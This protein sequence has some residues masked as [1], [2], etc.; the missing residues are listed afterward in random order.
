MSCM[1]DIKIMNLKT[2]KNYFHDEL[3]KNYSVSEIDS[4]FFIVISF[5]LEIS[6]LDYAQNSLQKINKTNTQTIIKKIE[7]LKKNMP[8]QYVLG[9]VF[10]KNI[11]FYLNKKVLIP[12]PETEELCDWIISCAKE[13]SNILD[14]GT[15][16][17]FIA[18][19]LKKHINNCKV[20][21]WDY[22]LEALKVAEKNA[23]LNNI[24]VT[25]RKVDILKNYNLNSKFDI[26]VS[27]P[28]YVDIS[29]KDEINA[30]VK[31]FEPHS[32]VFV[33]HYDNMIFYKK[34]IEQSKRLLKKNGI[35]YF[36][37]HSSRIN[38]LENMLKINNFK[39]IIIKEDMFGKK[40][41]I[42]AY[43]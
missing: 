29:E 25:L 15:G 13:K 19:I 17:G 34:I 27:N 41:M 1:D 22:S 35:L 32:A 14:I 30:R 31:Y 5:Y 40:R 42:S 33:E 8:I 36:E 16:S 10:H 12:R 6:K 4:L 21:A 39:R 23:K 11:K 28:P 3:K 9:V 43:K 24:D 2:L 18:I 26:I 20:E 7:L 38:I 37:S